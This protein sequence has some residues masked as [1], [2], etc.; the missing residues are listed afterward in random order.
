MLVCTEATNNIWPFGF[1][2]R[3]LTSY[4]NVFR[5]KPTEQYDAAD[6]L[7]LSYRKERI[8]KIIAHIKETPEW[9]ENIKNHAEEIGI[10]LEQALDDA[11]E[12]TYRTIIEPKAV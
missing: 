2:E 4:D 12:Y 10:T 9:L 6:S 8:E 7:Y 1:T 5:Y 3:Y 11:A